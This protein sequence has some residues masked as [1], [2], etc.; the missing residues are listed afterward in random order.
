M[1]DV[2]VPIYQSEVSP[3]TVYFSL[4]EISLEFFGSPGVCNPVLTRRS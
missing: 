3:G 1:M 4:T 2:I